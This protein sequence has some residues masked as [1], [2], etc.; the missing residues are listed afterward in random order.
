MTT[1]TKFSVDKVSQVHDHS[2]METLIKYEQQVGVAVD[3]VLF[4]I[5][6]GQLK[7]LLIE[8]RYPPYESNWALPGG[9]VKEGEAI[10]DAAL[11]E[12]EEET[13]VRA[14]YLEQLYTFGEPNRDPRGRVISVAYYAL[15][16]HQSVSPKES[17]E[18]IHVQWFPVE[19]MPQ[20]AFDHAQIMDYALER[21]RSKV[22]YTTVAF[23]LL[24]KKFTLSELQGAYEII[25]GHKLD[26]RN[27]RRKMA[28][29]KLLKAS[30]EIKKNR[31]YRP[32][33]LFSFVETRVIKLQEKGIL[34]PF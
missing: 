11:R 28:E 4:T 16:S 10:D 23:Q 5:D 12:L 2:V 24:P 26:K 21:L 33:Q 9:F 17:N 13:N 29:L 30:G 22:N 32:A 1:N 18:A 6:E 14:I 15:V 8:R 25:L 20:L 34:V 27:F 7:I 19:K 3:I 31:P